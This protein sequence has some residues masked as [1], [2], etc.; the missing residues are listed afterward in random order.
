M[1]YSTSPNLAIANHLGLEATQEILYVREFK[2][3]YLVVFVKGLCRRPTFVSK[4]VKQILDAIFK[5]MDVGVALGTPKPILRAKPSTPIV[6]SVPE[7]KETTYTVL[8]T[9]DNGSSYLGNRVISV[10][11]SEVGT[12]RPAFWASVFLKQCIEKGDVLREGN[13]S[14][15]VKVNQGAELEHSIYL[16]ASR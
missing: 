7:T 5:P 4:Q 1:N 16:G 15:L 14:R 12:R 6:V 11:V 3:V 10:L 2:Y 8:R 13:N 9:W